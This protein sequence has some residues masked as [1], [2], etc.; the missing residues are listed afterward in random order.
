MTDVTWPEGYARRILDAVDSTN[1]EAVRAAPGLNGPTWIMAKRQ[2]AGRGRRGRPWTDPAGNFAGTLVLRP[3][4]AP[5]IAALR[6][7]VAALALDDALAAVTGQPDRF[8]LK[9]PNDVLLDGCKLAG[10]LLESAGMGGQLS[11]LAIGMGVNLRSAPQAVE[12]GAIAPVSLRGTLG[13]EVTP[14]DFLTHLAAGY[15]QRE[16]QFC[17]AG[18]GAI[19]ADWLARAAKLGEVIT[20]RTSKSETV[21]T[22]QTVDETGNLV[23]ST[24]TGRVA[25]PAADVFF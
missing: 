1:A 22:F 20:A 24:R 19:R 16:T 21:G 5:G 13:V 15:A 14:E 9:W 12:T 18:F 4:E 17:D 8:A 10:I 6:S 2:I 7:F 3:S 11:H 25:I 23:L